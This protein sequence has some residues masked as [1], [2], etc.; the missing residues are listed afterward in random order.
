MLLY[1]TLEKTSHLKA[2]LWRTF[3]QKRKIPLIKKFISNNQKA[4]LDG[5]VD[6]WRKFLLDILRI[7]SES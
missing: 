2:D 3:L 7:E 6:L 4:S 1:K 5:L